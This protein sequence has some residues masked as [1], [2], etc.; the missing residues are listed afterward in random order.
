MQVP[1]FRVETQHLHIP[2]WNVLDTT[3]DVLFWL[4][5]LALTGTSHITQGNGRGRGR[6]LQ[7][8]FVIVVVEFAVAR[9]PCLNWFCRVCW[10]RR[11]DSG[12]TLFLNRSWKRVRKRRQPGP[13]ERVHARYRSACLASRSSLSMKIR[14]S[15]FKLFAG[16][17]TCRPG[18]LSFRDSNGAEKEDVS[19][20][21]QMTPGF[22]QYLLLFR[23]AVR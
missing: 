11:L 21:L 6:S 10:E 18:S 5:V 4:V 8:I 17:P 2:L 23:S 3:D 20:S 19:A 15:L 12:H 14:R 13:L 1:C 9:R 16:K 22:P 7:V